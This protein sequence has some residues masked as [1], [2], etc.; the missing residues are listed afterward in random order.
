MKKVLIFGC[1]HSRS[2]KDVKLNGF[3]III[4]THS[5][6]SVLGLKKSKSHLE[7]GKAIKEELKKDPPTDFV[8]LKLGQVDAENIFLYK[9]HIL[10]SEDSFDIFA[11]KVIESYDIFIDSLSGIISDKNIVICGVN[12]PSPA[13]RK[14][15]IK[16]Y[17]HTMRGGLPNPE[18]FGYLATD[19]AYLDDLLYENRILNSRS[20]NRKLKAFCTKRGIRFF[21]VF[22]E[23]LDKAGKIHKQ[24]EGKNFHIKG[25]NHTEKKDPADPVVKDIFSKA[26]AKALSG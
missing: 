15:V 4:H 21:E 17:L 10:K 9:K 14:R 23:L 22:E 1:S 8:V 7:V 13:D 6:A 12:P 20:F 19:Q 3:N 11:D 24:F 25:T 5:G 18:E 16:Q 2:F 26:L